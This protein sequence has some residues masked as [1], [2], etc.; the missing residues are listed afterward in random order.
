MSGIQA[1]L[2]TI[3]RR[4]PLYA[5]T[6][7]NRTHQAFWT[8]RYAEVLKSFRRVFV[9]SEMGLRKPEPAAFAAIA[10]AI[11]VPLE[12]IL[13]FDDNMGGSGRPPSPPASTPPA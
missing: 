13:F 10:A 12:R 4:L 3:A 5:L 9:S 8:I 11:D 2:G 6:N 1:L 7:S